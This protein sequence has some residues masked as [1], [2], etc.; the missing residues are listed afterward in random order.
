MHVGRERVRA[1]R[2]ARHAGLQLLHQ[3]GPPI[4]ATLMSNIK[5]SN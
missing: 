4:K 5:S 3:L 1:V 2:N